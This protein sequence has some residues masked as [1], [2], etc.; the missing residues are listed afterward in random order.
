[1][2]FQDKT[3]TC[4]E[5]GVAFLFTSGEQE[6]Y[7]QKG[8]LNEPQRCPACRAAK[9]RE[10][11]GKSRIAHPVTCSEC[12]TETTVPFIPRYDRPVYCN[13]C[14]DRMRSLTPPNA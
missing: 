7:A 13:S 6:F 5:C 3:L 9:R 4:K 2:D 11:T 8:L 14:F 12:G 10:R 1:M